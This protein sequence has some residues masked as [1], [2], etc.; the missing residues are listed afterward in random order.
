MIFAVYRVSEQDR[1]YF[2]GFGDR[3]SMRTK[4]PSHMRGMKFLKNGVRLVDKTTTYIPATWMV[5]FVGK[6][7]RRIESMKYMV[8]LTTGYER[9]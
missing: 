9:K 4:M 2:M 6:A 5:I 1:H 8:L 3:A 7:F